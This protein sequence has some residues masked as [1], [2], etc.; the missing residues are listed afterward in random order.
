[1]RNNLSKTA[2]AAVLFVAS[3]AAFAGTDTS[4]LTVSATVDANCTIDASGGVAFG[5]YDPVSANSAT[6]IDLD[7]SSS[8]ISTTCTTGSAATITLGQGANADTGSTD[9]APLRQMISGAD[10]LSYNLYTDSAG[11]T[12]WDNVTGV[13]V[14]GTGAADSV[15]VYGRIP[16]GQNVPVGSY[17]DTVVATVTF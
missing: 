6:G 4:N 1:M 16:K 8:T 7:N 5:T 14:T 11:G 2:L 15:N 17:S 10:L 3:A 9:S 12:V 13:D